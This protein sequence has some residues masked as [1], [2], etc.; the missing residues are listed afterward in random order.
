MQFPLIG[1]VALAM[2]TLVATAV[3]AAG[4]ASKG[5]E[6]FLRTCINCHSTEIGVNKIG[7]SLHGVVGRKVAIVPDFVYSDALKA[8]RKTWTEAELDTYLADPRGAMHG[9][10]MFFKGLPDADQR[11]DVIAYLKTLN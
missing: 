5:K 2:T 6:I 3:W 4:D 11:A 10:K 1:T 7:P 8:T 9:V